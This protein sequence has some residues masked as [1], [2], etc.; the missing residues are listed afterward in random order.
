MINNFGRLARIVL[1]SSLISAVFAPAAHA[2]DRWWVCGTGT[3]LWSFNSCWS[4]TSGGTGGAT[5]PQVGDA[6]RFEFND[7]IN[8][9]I[10]LT[11]STMTSGL[12]TV[13]MGNGG[14][15]TIELIQTAGSLTSTI[16][17]IGSDVGG[18][19]TYTQ[20]G[21][22]NTTTGSFG[23]LLIGGSGSTGTYNLQGG[24]L[25][26]V[27]QNVGWTNIG[28]FNHSAGSNTSTE[29]FNLGTF[30]SGN[31][32]YNLSGTGL[33]TTYD[34]Y[35]GKKGTGTFIQT[36]GT[37]TADRLFYIGFDPGAQGSYTLNAGSLTSNFIE[38][39][40]FQGKGT[41]IHAAGTHLVNGD[42]ILGELIGSTGNYLLE[43]TSS[44][45][46][47]STT[48]TIVGDNGD[49]F[50]SH[51]LTT[52]F[53]PGTHTVTGT[54]TL[55]KRSTGEGSYQMGNGSLSAGSIIVGESGDG[56]FSQSAAILG[57]GSGLVSSV[58]A[59]TLTLGKNAGSFGVYNLSSFPSTA[60]A[61]TTTNTIVGANGTAIFNHN[62][63]TNRAN[64]T[65]TIGSG[66]LYNLNATDASL[67][68]EVKN[69]T[70]AS[71]GELQA[72]A[73][74]T[75]TIQSVGTG[76]TVTNNGTIK[77]QPGTTLIFEHQVLNGNAIVLDPATIE[78]TDITHSATGYITAGTGDSVRVSG[79][80]FNNSTQNTVW[81]TDAAAL[82]IDGAGSHDF[83]IAGKDQGKTGIGYIDN[84][85]WGELHVASGAS[86]NFFDGN[87]SNS[88]TALYVGW[89]DL[90]NGISQLAMFSSLFNIYYDMNLTENA[91]L[92]GQD[93]TLAGGGFLLAATSAVPVPGAVWLFSSALG[94]LGWMRRSRRVLSSTEIIS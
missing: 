94:L 93:Y 46:S 92:L 12:A 15:G 50:F 26:T 76:G 48:N 8:R 90:E 4:T 83:H 88:G 52:G 86:I 55:G 36:G 38:F 39:I 5:L 45:P 54:L 23:G 62:S 6:A 42:L 7:S 66:G 44:N 47:L 57:P 11:S 63:G 32:T 74:G 18:T 33:L 70:I 60:G 9:T 51:G 67:S 10:Y 28:T 81:D 84:F 71:G 64:D 2:A 61:L 19:V 56:I 58:T 80:W 40:G 41:F 25:S 69:L 82:F 27:E 34:V 16:E 77:V 43:G 35:I 20:Q 37:H 14:L 59:N 53:N 22:T 75:V 72:D 24:I 1:C 87:T 13:A 78:L 21:G 31:G 79:H 65:L 3:N 89:L 29:D 30:S 91:Y 85:M 49:G 68:L 73:S 17:A